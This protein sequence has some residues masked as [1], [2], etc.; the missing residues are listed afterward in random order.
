[1]LSLPPQDPL[2]WGAA[3][4]INAVLI[5]CAQRLPLLTPAG[6]VHAGLLGTLLWGSLG[7]AGWLAVATYLALGS[8]VTKLGFRRKREL[9]LAEAR[10]GRRGPENVWGSALVGAVLALL[11]TH[12]PSGW[13][14]VLLVGFAASFAAKL[15]DSFGSEI[16]K[17]WGRHTVLITSLRPV[18]PGTE[19]AISLE[20]TAASLLGCALMTLVM[21]RLGLIGGW[22]TAAL[23]AS[24]GLI[25]TL[26]ESVVGAS[27]QHRWRWL[28]NELVNG[29][30]T[31]L[32]AL[33][34][35]G[36][37]RWLPVA[38]G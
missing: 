13:T 20:G 8:L 31:L 30:Q 2:H 5:A 36:L 1:M 21:L 34:A 19:G 27:L 17:R 15:G 29:L 14:P 22:S 7:P 25:A 10:G 33:M 24:V 38:L 28:S 12:T 35:M 4:A 3:L 18:P 9:G 6:W 37:L 23:V 26:L 11:T 16:G 32:A